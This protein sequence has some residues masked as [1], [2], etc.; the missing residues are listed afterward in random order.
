MCC[1]RVGKQKW[2]MGRG[3]ER[4]YSDIREDDWEKAEK[5]HIS[6]ISKGE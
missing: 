5:E 2:K 1:V 6:V 4:G 3:E